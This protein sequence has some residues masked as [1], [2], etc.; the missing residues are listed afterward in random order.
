MLAVC[1]TRETVT[2][3]SAV[4]QLT[5]AYFNP[6]SQSSYDIRYADICVTGAPVRVTF[7]GTDPVAGTT[8]RTWYPGVT[9]RVWGTALLAALKAIRDTS[10]DGVFDVSY[11]GGTR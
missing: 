2:V 7:Q 10:T 8:G 1:K 5:A 9:Y 4:K 3:S 11:F 6:D